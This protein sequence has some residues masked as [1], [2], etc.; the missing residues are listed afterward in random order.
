[1]LPA[2][3][4]NGSKKKIKFRKKVIFERKII[5]DENNVRK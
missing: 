4:A 2:L 1:M 5:R 3:W